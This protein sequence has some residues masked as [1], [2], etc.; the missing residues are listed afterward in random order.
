MSKRRARENRRA[1]V[2]SLF[3]DA[4]EFPSALFQLLRLRML[5]IS[6]ELDFLRFGGA[7]H[8]VNVKFGLLG[9]V[10]RYNK[11]FLIPTAC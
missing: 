10:P 11:D 2:A 3:S 1:V 5:R 4:H 6:R 7:I 8:S 9:C